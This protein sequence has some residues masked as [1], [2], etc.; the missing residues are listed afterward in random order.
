VRETIRGRLR[1]VGGSAAARA[2]TSLLRDERFSSI[3]FLDALLGR[4]ALTARLVR[5][6]RQAGLRNRVGEVVLYMPLLACTGLLAG[7][8]ITGNPLISLTLAATGGLL[9]LLVVQRMRRKRLRQ[10]SEQL[11]DA[12]DLVRA[13]L[14]AGHALATALNVVADEFPNPVAEEFG[15]VAEEIRLGMPLREALYRLRDRVDDPNVPLLVLGILIAHEVGGNL[16][17]VLDNTAYTVRER[18]KLAREVQVMTAQG[19]LS[20]M[21]LTGLP[22]AVGLFMYFLNPTYFAPMLASQTGLYMLGYAFVSIL[23]GHFVIQR[24]VRIRT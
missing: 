3:P 24:I 5:V 9:P 23:A 6:I 4:L 17:E 13:A 8:L 2:R 14:Q 12:L 22:V 15:I 10:F 21:V 11:P 18:F 16:A 7:T 1:A 20:G 19:R